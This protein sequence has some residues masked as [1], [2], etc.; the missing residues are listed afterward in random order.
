MTNQTSGRG[1]RRRGSGLAAVALLVAP[2][3]IGSVLVFTP[4]PAAAATPPATQARGPAAFGDVAST[5]TRSGSVE[6]GASGRVSIAPNRLANGGLNSAGGT[7]FSNWPTGDV[8][9]HAAGDASLHLRDCGLLHDT[10]CPLGAAELGFNERCVTATEDSILGREIPTEWLP[11]HR[12][13]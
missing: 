4:S 7:S 8:H 1:G 2:M 9:A 12:M 10:L 5:S 3:L 13:C 6:T 11:P